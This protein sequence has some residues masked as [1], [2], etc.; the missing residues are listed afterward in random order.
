MRLQFSD[1]VL[2]RW[3]M[4]SIP[5]LSVFV[6]AACAGMTQRQ[7]SPQEREVLAKRQRAMLMWKTRCEK[8]GV[9]IHKRIENVD[10]LYLVNVRVRSNF[11][12]TAEDQFALDDPYGHDSIGENYMK[13]FLRGAH[14]RAPDGGPP[15]PDAPRNGFPFV[16]AIDPRDGK[17]YRFTGIVKSS[18]GVISRL[19]LARTPILNRTARYG[20]QYQD[21]STR[22]ERELWIAGSSL[23]LIDLDTDEVVAERIGYMVDWAQG[24]RAGNRLPWLWA[25][26]NACPDFLHGLPRRAPA[27]TAQPGQ[28]LDFVERVF[29]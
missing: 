1:S 15:Y 21:I 3:A 4:L 25:A 19:E 9:F 6:L 12:E 5:L 22:Q 26:D 8:S 20:L 13:S 10:G 23:K 17:L 11:G 24:S 14:P 7:A 28:S 27:S 18:P 29:K 16:E 2:M